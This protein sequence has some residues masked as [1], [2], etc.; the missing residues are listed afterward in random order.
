MLWYVA[1]GV[2]FG[3]VDCLLAQLDLARPYDIQGTLIIPL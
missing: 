2:A 3:K 1:I